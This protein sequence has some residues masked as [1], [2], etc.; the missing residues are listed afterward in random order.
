MGGQSEIFLLFREK[1]LVFITA[2]YFYDIVHL[3]MSLIS[4]TFL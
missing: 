1:K 4:G 2:L 3:I